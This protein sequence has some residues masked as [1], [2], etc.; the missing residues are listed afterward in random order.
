MTT[1]GQDTIQQ[2]GN[3]GFAVTARDS[4]GCQVIRWVARQRVANSGVGLSRIGHH[5]LGQFGDDP[6]FGQQH[7]GAVCLGLFDMLV[8]IFVLIDQGDKQ[9][10]LAAFVPFAAT[11]LNQQIVGPKKRRLRKHGAQTNTLTS[12][13]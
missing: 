11:G 6:A 13:T 9:I 7:T 10:A 8:P 5:T 2:K 12:N 4:N 3:A 1:G